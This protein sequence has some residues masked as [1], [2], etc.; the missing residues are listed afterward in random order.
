MEELPNSTRKRMLELEGSPLTEAQREEALDAYNLNPGAFERALAGAEKVAHA[1]PYFISSIRRIKQEEKTAR[2]VPPGR[3]HDLDDPECKDCG[4]SGFVILLRDISDYALEGDAAP[5]HCAAGIEKQR[6]YGTVHYGPDDY[7]PAVVETPRISALQYAQT[8][9]GK[10]DP[11]M[12]P[13]ML[14]QLRKVWKDTQR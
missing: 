9:E 11:N 13:R 14:D 1:A 12:N 8:P 5:C 3:R 2:A 4:D 6:R 10:A 7:T